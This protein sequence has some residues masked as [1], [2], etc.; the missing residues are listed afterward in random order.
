VRYSVAAPPRLSGWA[1]EGS[2]QFEPTCAHCLNGSTLTKINWN[3]R[4]SSPADASAR[5][6]RSLYTSTKS[7][8]LRFSKRISSVAVGS[9]FLT[10]VGVL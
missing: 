5:P 1:Y 3:C 4:M 10:S 2:S 6:Q 8:P 9:R 7:L